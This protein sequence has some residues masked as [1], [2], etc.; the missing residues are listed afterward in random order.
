MVRAGIAF[1]SNLGDRAA[2]IE[3]ARRRLAEVS[4]LRSLA[5][6]AL[7]EGPPIGPVEQGPFLNAVDLFEVD[8]DPH[9]CLA[10]L[11]AIEESLGRVRV[12]RWGPRAIDLDLLFHGP[13]VVD[14]ASLTLPHPE[15]AA[16]S[17]VLV[18]LVEVAPT[19]RHPVSGRTARELLADLRAGVAW[20]PVETHRA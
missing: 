18:P 6:S 3:A 1:G 2:A 16:R 15:L 7:Y 20:T 5:R 19:W 4:G 12:E 11:L 17:F 14:D 8:L 10:A 9:A 13:A